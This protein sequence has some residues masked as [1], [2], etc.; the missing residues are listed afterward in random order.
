MGKSFHAYP[1][2]PQTIAVYSR[3]EPLHCN[4]VEFDTT[5]CFVPWV[6][7]NYATGCFVAPAP[8][9]VEFHA[10]IL[11]QGPPPNGACINVWFMKNT[12]PTVVGTVGGEIAGDDCPVY[13]PPNGTLFNM[14]TRLTRKLS[15]LAGE[16]VWCVP[17]INC[18]GQ[19]TN[20][21]G[22]NGNNAV[23]YFEG[24]ILELL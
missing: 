16:K 23:N 13:Q 11:I 2:A 22:G 21:I 3:N 18:G 19:L 7:G 20:A 4:V 15:L 1:S 8:C 6:P 14:S 12:L 17:G 5:G 9:I 10:N 24:H